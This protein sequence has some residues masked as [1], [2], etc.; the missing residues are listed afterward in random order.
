MARPQNRKR[1]RADE[2]SQAD[3][4]PPAKKIKTRSELELEAWES[5]E[6]PPEFYDRLSKISL[7]H[8]ALK[9]LDRR[10]RTRRC[11]PSPPSPA[12][13]SRRV[14]SRATTSR[15]LARFARHGGPDLRDLRGASRYELGL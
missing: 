14:F 11:D 9:E 7:S 13:P 1:Q 5:W 15:E 12:S 3:I 10:T 2:P 6:Y 8:R 4:D